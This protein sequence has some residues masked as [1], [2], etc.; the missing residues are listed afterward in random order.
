MRMR[1]RFLR[2]AQSLE[3][4]YTAG[5]QFGLNTC[6]KQLDEHKGIEQQVKSIYTCPKSKRLTS[7]I[8]PKVSSCC[9]RV[10]KMEV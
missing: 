3:S 2:R 9:K 6:L 10:V 8:Q 5:G 7:G 1:L 4:L